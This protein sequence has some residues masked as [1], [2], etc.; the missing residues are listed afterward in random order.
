M[1]KFRTPEAIF[2][3]MSHLIEGLSIIWDKGIVHRDLKPE[4]IIIRED[5]KPC[6]I[7][8]GIARFLDQESLTNTLAPM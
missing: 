7:D 4:N 3:L 8:L 6:I 5:G 1:D 2:Q